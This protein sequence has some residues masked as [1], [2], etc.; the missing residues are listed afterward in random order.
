M[1]KIYIGAPGRL[2]AKVT[3]VCHPPLEYTLCLALPG[4][5]IARATKVSKVLTT[6]PLFWPSVKNS[7]SLV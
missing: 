5:L 7:N 3:T 2:H 4:L 6:I 1:F